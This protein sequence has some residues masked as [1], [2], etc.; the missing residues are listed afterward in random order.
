MLIPSIDLMGGKIVQLVQGESKAYETTDFD[1]WCDRF[2]SFPLVQLIDLDAAKRQGD[3]RSL[4]AKILK[5]LPCQ[6]GGGVGD[7]P[8]AEALLELGAKRVILG[9]SLIREGK[10]DVDFARSVADA[11]G[12]ERIVAAI[13][14]RGGVVAVRGWRESTTLAAEQM[15][16]ALEPFVSGFLYT[17]VDTEGLLAG[18][19][20]ERAQTLRLRTQRNLI[21]AGGIRSQA[22]IDA[23]D[24]IQVDAV[25][26][27]AIYTGKLDLK[28]APSLPN[29]ESRKTE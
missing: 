28:Q 20:F 23:L 22:E 1:A 2:A 16:D 4:I 29:P 5:R 11:C 21:A 12:A 24:A 7:L 25:V 26:G 3:N 8:K 6:V 15:I 10:P 27:M 18:F 9:S 17:H 19:P 13:D 14:S